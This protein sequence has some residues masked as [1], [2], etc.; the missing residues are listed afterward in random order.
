MKLSYAHD[1]ACVYVCV[2]KRK[3][4][5]HIN[6]LWHFTASPQFLC[7]YSS[8]QSSCKTPVA[9]INTHTHSNTHSR[10]HAMYEAC[11]LL[12]L[13]R[14]T[15]LFYLEIPT[16]GA[17]SPLL[18][19]HPSVSLFLSFSVPVSLPIK[20]ITRHHKESKT[21]AHVLRAC[22]HRG[23]S[24][25]PLTD[26]R[27]VKAI[28]RC[29]DLR[30]HMVPVKIF[31]DNPSGWREALRAKAER[32]F[33]VC[34]RFPLWRDEAFLYVRKIRVRTGETHTSLLKQG[35]IHMHWTRGGASSTLMKMLTVKFMMAGVTKPHHSAAMRQ[36]VK[37]MLT[38]RLRSRRG[39][40]GRMSRR[41]RP[42]G[43]SVI[44]K[45]LMVSPFSL[46]LFFSFLSLSPTNTHS[47]NWPFLCVF[48]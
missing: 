10:G 7:S 35:H 14:I 20:I 21:C 19:L 33:C 9:V 2:I 11:L 41:W 18:R 28:S 13:L 29:H 15:R 45:L 34:N 16:P 47:A 32:V 25:F 27:Y 40:D 37:E 38:E 3:F 4:L 44:K 42:R 22:S 26:K 8:A 43:T 48:S 12:V 24:L 5:W 1:D 30:S 23:V 17:T 31:M 46:S 6:C 36:V 39:M